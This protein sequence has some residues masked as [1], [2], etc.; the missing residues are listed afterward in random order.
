MIFNAIY[1]IYFIMKA[2][3]LNEKNESSCPFIHKHPFINENV[4]DYPTQFSMF[5]QG[6]QHSR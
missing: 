2:P 5:G 3:F 1:L 6:S 4:Y